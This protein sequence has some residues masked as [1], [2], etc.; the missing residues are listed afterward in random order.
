MRISIAQTNVHRGE[1]ERNLDRIRELAVSASR[2][3]AD[4][5]CLPEMATTG[6]DWNRNRCLLDHAENHLMELS[7]IANFSGIGICGSFLEKTASGRPANTLICFGDSG[8]ILSRYR[9]IHLFSVF[10]EQEHVEA[11]ETAV[12]ADIGGIIIG[13]GICYDLRFPELFRRNMELGAK[14]Q[15]LPAAFP[16][17]RLEHWRTLIKARAIENQCFFIAVNQCGTEGHDGSVGSVQY[18]GHSMVV[19]PWGEVLFEAGETS[20][21]SCVD[22]DL[23]RVESAR[24]KLPALQDRRTDLF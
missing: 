24:G 23:V 22:L 7:S 14:V 9:K 20:E 17:P 5:L 13:F 6:F 1:P 8:E 3:G 18:F 4:L 19:D 2:Q 12:V 15:F 21:L 16:H 10:R 11:G